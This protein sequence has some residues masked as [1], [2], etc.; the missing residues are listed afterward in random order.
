MASNLSLIDNKTNLPKN[1]FEDKIINILEEINKY[2]N[3]IQNREEIKNKI[4]K[5]LDDYNNKLNNLK[6]NNGL[7]LDSKESIK[8]ELV[9]NLNIILDKLKNYYENNKNY[10]KILNDL[11][12]IINMF[13]GENQETNEDNDLTKDLKVIINYCIPFLKEEDKSKI[14]NNLLKIITDEKE[15]ITK[16]LKSIENFDDNILLKE[17]EKIDYSTYEEFEISL[18]RKM[19]PILIELNTNV[20]KRDIELEIKEGL[21]K[22]SDNL[23]E[24]LKGKILSF[25]LNEIKNIKKEI[26]VSLI[27]VKNKDN[28][29][30]KLKEI[31][32]REIDY[33]KDIIEILKDIN[34]IIV[35]LHKLNYKI[36]EQLINDNDY[37]NSRLN[38]RFK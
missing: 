3:N 34:T 30:L 19:H 35:S 24:E 27:Q 23:F 37:N 10:Y 16:Y 25:Y 15:I 18:R 14:N 13:T 1:E 21:K 38:V 8:N 5:L 4:N 28:Y 20:N 6:N 33:S 26:D 31:L 29:S 17:T 12:V 11:D 7:S 2:C 9:T 36:K 32:S 22:I